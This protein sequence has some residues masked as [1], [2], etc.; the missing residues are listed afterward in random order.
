MRRLLELLGIGLVAGFLS[1]LFGVGGGVV[2]VPLLLARG[3]PI[4]VATATSLAAIIATAVFGAVRYTWSGDVDFSDAVLI[5]DLLTSA[6]VIAALGVFAGVISGLFGVGGGIIF[7]P[8]LTLILGRHQLQAE[9]TSLAAIVPVAIV[10]SWRQH[11]E[12]LVRWKT[13]AIIGVASIGG[14]LAGAEVATSLSNK[15]LERAFGVFLVAASIQLGWK[16]WHA[17]QATPL[18]EPELP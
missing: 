5:G 13:A 12:G 10:G 7:V 8:A 18:A 15:A 9:A 14:V 16:A 17:R 4:K 2:I 11:R 1:A 6:L 3:W